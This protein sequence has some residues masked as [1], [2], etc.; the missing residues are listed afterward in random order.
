LGLEKTIG[1]RLRRILA[2]ADRAFDRELPAL[3][4][5]ILA[6]VRRV[7]LFMFVG[8]TWCVR[9]LQAFADPDFQDPVSALDWF[10]V[11]SFSAALFG[12]AC[13]LPLFAQLIGG[14]AVLGASLVPA[15][16]SALSGLS[17]LLEDAFQ[18]G[19]AFWFFV[20][21]TALTMLGFLGF[22]VA[23][24]VMGRGRR[25]FSA[26]VPAVTLV[27]ILLFES[28]GGLLIL[29]AWLVA[30]AITLGRPSLTSPQTAAAAP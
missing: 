29:G 12:L 20:A 19:F 7:A 4:L 30:A 3:A 9:S 11:L 5:P 28:G 18:I 27:G 24:A 1:L 15:V 21:S 23:V 17:N 25:R 13:A 10:A 16:G 2:T 8:V 14:R 6:F 22:T 26:A